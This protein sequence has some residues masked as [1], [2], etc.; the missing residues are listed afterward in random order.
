MIDMSNN[1]GQSHY[2]PPNNYNKEPQNSS[3]NPTPDFQ[4]PDPNN[5]NNATNYV[6][7]G[8]MAMPPDAMPYLPSRDPQ[9]ELYRQAM[10]RA[11]AKLRFFAHLKNYLLVNLLLWSIAI[12]STIGDWGH[13]F[14]F[15]STF[16]PL[17]VTVFWGIGLVSEYVHVYV[18]NDQERKQQMIEAE[19]RRLR[20]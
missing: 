9:T 8:P 4:W 16:W 3:N 6:V 12:I 20:R 17:W 19:M 14:S 5:P 1:F 13:H 15:W 7:P 11:D 2:Q 18:V 10:Q